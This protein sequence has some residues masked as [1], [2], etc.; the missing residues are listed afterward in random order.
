MI[1]VIVLVDANDPF[2]IVVGGGAIASACFATV[3]G[4][5][6]TPP[7]RIGLLLALIDSRR[8]SL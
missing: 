5:R 1:G 7:A 4:W 2:A 3:S 6:D 8:V